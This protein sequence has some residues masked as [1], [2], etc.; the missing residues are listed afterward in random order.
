MRAYVGQ[1]ADGRIALLGIVSRARR[2]D[3][4]GSFPGPSARGAPAGGS[5]RE[6]GRH[7]VHAH[8]GLQRV[9]LAVTA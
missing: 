2:P 6:W 5:C 4:R 1:T 3:Q 7:R 9:L 8:Q